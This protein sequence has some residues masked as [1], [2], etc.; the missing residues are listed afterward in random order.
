MWSLIQMTIYG[1]RDQSTTMSCSHHGVY[2]Q[3]GEKSLD[4]IT[5][6]LLL[7]FLSIFTQHD[8]HLVEQS[9][10]K[11]CRAAPYILTTLN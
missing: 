10:V 3:S 1:T 7:G 6:L 9:P 2:R 5:C 11:P 8:T 4:P